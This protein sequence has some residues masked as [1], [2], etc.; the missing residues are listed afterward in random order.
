MNFKEIYHRANDQLKADPALIRLVKNPAIDKAEKRYAMIWL[1]ASAAAVIAVIL[2][3]TLL[4]QQTVP[5]ITLGTSSVGAVSHENALGSVAS[6]EDASSEPTDGETSTEEEIATSTLV[7]EPA[8]APVEGAKALSLSATPK[9]AGFQQLSNSFQSAYETFATQSSALLLKQQDGVNKLV[10]PASLFMATAM[11]A[12][13]T[14]GETRAEILK[15]LQ[16]SA[17]TDLREQ[18][19][20]FYSNNYFAHE[21]G[22]LQIANSI[23]INQKATVKQSLTDT[24]ATKYY[25]S[26][27][28]AAFGTEAAVKQL[29]Q[30]LY[31]NTGGKLGDRIPAAEDSNTFMILINAIYYRDQWDSRFLAANNRK[32]PF[33][34]A[35]GKAVEA[36]YLT[37]DA[38]QQAM[39]GNGYKLV[40][41]HL[42]GS[43][44]LLVLPDEGQSVMAL[45]EDP[46]RLTEIFNAETQ[47]YKVKLELPKFTMTADSDLTQA[48]PLLGVKQVFAPG[49]ANFSPTTELPLYVSEAA[50]KTFFSVNEDGCEAAAYTY[51]A[52]KATGMPPTTEPPAMTMQLNRPFLFAIERNGTPL[53]IGVMNDPTAK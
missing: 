1:S 52:D 6:S 53:F 36:E 22:K 43:Q 7:N 14:A 45:A 37:K 41:L 31:D 39:I 34:R 8:P 51:Y 11:L 33:T 38:T 28:H 30:W 12:E 3:V 48:L 16:A 9:Q 42:S 26:S 18:V 15:L 4:F 27:Y 29:Q 24:L 40:R 17:L 20:K 5:V 10:S 46:K 19:S 23:W 47:E 50:Q 21:V 2:C 35:D 25:A 13:A 44:L 49:V 32:A